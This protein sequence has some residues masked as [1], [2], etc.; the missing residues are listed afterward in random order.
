VVVRLLGGSLGRDT[1]IVETNNLR[2]AEDSLNDGWLD[3]NGS[4]YSEQAKFTEKIRRPAYD[5]LQIYMTVED[6]QAYTK[7]WTVRLDQRLIVH[8]DLIEFEIQ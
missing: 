3:V 4:P 6:P 5:H 8:Q 2:G 1:L 7:T